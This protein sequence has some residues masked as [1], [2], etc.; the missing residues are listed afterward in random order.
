MVEIVHFHDCLRGEVQHFAAGARKL[1]W[2][3]AAALWLWLVCF[4]GVLRCAVWNGRSHTSDSDPAFPFS[5]HSPRNNNRAMVGGVGS[6]SKEAIDL[7]AQ[8]HSQ[9][10]SLRRVFQAHSKVGGCWVGGVR[11]FARRGWMTDLTGPRHA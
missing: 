3:V 4:G 5:I 8:L 6:F 11:H 7:E 1:R 2:V 10:H 9:F